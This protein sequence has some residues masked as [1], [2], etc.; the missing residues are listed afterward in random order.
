[1]GDSPAA[2]F[3]SAENKAMLWAALRDAGA[4]QDMQPGTERQ[5]M[6]SIETR[7]VQAAAAGDP[8]AR[9]LTQLNK[10][11]LRGVLS[12]LGASGQR[13]TAARG[14]PGVARAF[15]SKQAQ[16]EAMTK[17]SQPRRIDFS[18][19]LDTP[20]GSEMERAI[21]EA[22]NLRTAQT[23]ASQSQHQGTRKQAEGWL[24]VQARKPGAAPPAMQ[25]KIGDRVDA[26]EVGTI[27]LPLPVTPAN[28]RQVRFSDGHQ[29]PSS[30][31]PAPAPPAGGAQNFLSALKTE[32]PA[33]AGIAE[34]L[35]SID[36]SLQTIASAL[37]QLAAHANKDG[38]AHPAR[39]Q[40]PTTERAST[41]SPISSSGSGPAEIDLGQEN[42][43]GGE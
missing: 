25:L 32:K 28:P 33:T 22:V 37:T 30:A 18:D 34:K 4:F 23:N 10:T 26:A 3:H 42:E 41:P 11:V 27:P 12:D 7:M 35:A 39:A 5:V 29:P 36:T 38:S 19:E 8:A 21:Q 16:I 13:P 1:M 43:D 40:S 2:T 17:G 24:G 15:A 6:S 31:V 9:D 20:M 14:D